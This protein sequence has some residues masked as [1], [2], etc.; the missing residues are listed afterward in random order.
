MTWKDFPCRRWAFRSNMATQIH[1]AGRIWTSVNRQL[2]TSNLTP[3][4]NMAIAPTTKA[5]GAKMRC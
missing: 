4:N 3:S 1:I 2:V 5:S